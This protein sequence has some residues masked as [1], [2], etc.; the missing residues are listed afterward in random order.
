MKMTGEDVATRSK[1]AFVACV[2]ICLTTCGYGQSSNIVSLSRSGSNIVLQ[3]QS[4]TN[5]VYVVQRES[6]L[7]PTSSWSDVAWTFGGTSSNSWT[8][9]N[10]IAQ[11]QE[12]YRLVSGG[13]TN[14]NNGIP[15]SWAVTNGLD[16]LDPNLASED[17]AND[18]LNNYQNYLQGSDPLASSPIGVKAGTVYAG[19]SSNTASVIPALAPMYSFNG[20]SPWGMIQSSIDSN[21]YGTAYTNTGSQI[22]FKM[23]PQGIVTTLYPFYPINSVTDG[24]WLEMTPI[25][26]SDSNFYGLCYFG[27]NTTASYCNSGVIGYGTA[28]RL[29]EQ[30]VLTNLHV[31]AGPPEGSCPVGGLIQATDGNFY[32]VTEDGGSNNCSDSP[33]EVGI[34]DIFGYCCDPHY[35]GYGTVFKLTPQGTFTTLY[36]FSGGT[37][38]AW[39]ET[40]LLQGSDGYLYGTTSGGN[41]NAGTVFKVSTNGS[42]FAALHAFSGAADGATPYG[43]LIQ[44]GGGYL[45]GTTFGG[46]TNA[47]GTVF[48]VDTNGIALVTLHAFDGSDGSYPG[49]GLTQGSNGVFYGTTIY[50]GS[51]GDG[52]IF[53]ITPQGTL[54]TVYEFTGAADGENPDYGTLV[55]SAIDGELYGTTFYSGANDWGTAFRYAPANYTW[56]ISGGVVTG[57]QGSAYISFTATSLCA[58]TLSV[59]MTNTALDC[60]N[61]GSITVIPDAPVPSANSPINAGQTLNLSVPSIGG[62][63]Y[64]WTGPDSFVSTNQYLSIANAQPCISGLYCVTTTADGCTSSMSC[65]SVTVDA[66]QPTSDSPLCAGQTLNLSVSSVAGASYSWSGP[67][68]YVSTNRNPSIS[69]ISLTATGT[70]CVAV[71]ANGCTSTGCVLVTVK[72]LATANVS[73][74]TTTCPG[75]LNTIEATLTGT[76]PWILWWSDGVVTTN[77]GDVVIR[78][79]SP[80]S[81]TTYTVTN[82]SDGLCSGGTITG[83]ATVTV[84]TNGPTSS[85]VVSNN[86]LVVYNSNTNFPDSLSCMNYYINHRPGFSNANV[87]ACS[88]T[89]TGTDGFESITTANL[90]NQ[91]INPIVNFMQSNT[92]KS[93]HYVVLMY[94]MPS[95]VSDGTITCAPSGSCGLASVQHHISRCLSDASYTSGPYYDTGSVTCPYVATNYLGTTCLVTALNLATL[96]DCTAYVDKVTSMYT[97]NV[98]ISAKEAGYTN[99]NYYLDDTRSFAYQGSPEALGFRSAIL[100]ENPG[101]SVVFSS[102]AV[103]TAGSALKGYAGWGVHNGVWTSNPDYA[104]DG[105]VAWSG[106]ATWWMIETFESYNGT[107]DCGSSEGQN[108]GC[109]EQWFST[110]AWGGVNYANTPVGAVSHVEEPGLEGVSGPTYMSLWEEGFPFSECAWASKNTPCFQAVGDPLVKQ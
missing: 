33:V 103:I 75:V 100:A 67:D 20:G 77:S 61:S 52:T 42:N 54:T 92:V 79:V 24:Y 41:T 68:G 87:L 29:T 85:V 93:I 99:V 26:A 66:L 21:F 7:I 73:G 51:S 13:A 80:S 83:N 110:N 65:V 91:I 35:G 101:A 9:T 97:S 8:D 23:T 40:A 45:Y 96:A 16:P 76:S 12:F 84:N 90:T 47:D 3:W 50:G 82:L 4:T 57:G 37:D 109:V 34:F 88:C 78:T 81:T 31:F 74:S 102:N 18:C 72:P 6:S 19:S 1:A 71:V 104:T 105:S 95:R 44:D 56:S 22:I 63:T 49:T 98:I 43:A 62:A 10:A 94:G 70:Y 58:V 30:G 11:A 39:P 32:G 55:Q 69:N 86:V 38:G 28:F 48:K 53:Q 27:G 14:L 107:R 106:N 64:A 108:Q 59:T 5:D 36:T 17:P 60:S 46:G 25:Q 15:Y 2:L 89:T